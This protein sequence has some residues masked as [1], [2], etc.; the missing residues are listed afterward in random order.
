MAADEQSAATAIQAMHRG[1]MER[2]RMEYFKARG[3][4]MPDFSM[5]KSRSALM[6]GTQRH[7]SPLLRDSRFCVNDIK[8]LESLFSKCP[9][10]DSVSSLHDDA[11]SDDFKPSHVSFVRAT[12]AAMMAYLIQ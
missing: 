11:T 6:I 8:A 2:Q 7:Q 4:P 10:Y 1:R 12:A 9:T 3:R 5:T